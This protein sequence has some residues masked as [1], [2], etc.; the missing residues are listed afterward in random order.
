[1]PYD[2]DAL[3]VMILVECP[4]SSPEFPTRAVVFVA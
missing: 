4:V 3:V 2:D 1:M